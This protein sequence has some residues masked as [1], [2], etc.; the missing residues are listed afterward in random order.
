MKKTSLLITAVFAAAL[1]LPLAGC[2]NGA[3]EFKIDDYALPLDSPFLPAGTLSDKKAVTST[4]K[5]EGTPD[6]VLGN[7]NLLSLRFRNAEEQATRYKLFDTEA[8][9]FVTEE[10]FDHIKSAGAGFVNCAKLNANGS[11][12]AA[13]YS[14]AGERM[15]DAYAMNMYSFPSVTNE[16]AYVNGIASSVYVLR[17]FTAAGQTQKTEKYYLQNAVTGG[18]D[19]IDSDRVS[20]T[21]VEL[22]VG[23]PFNNYGSSSYLGCDKDGTGRTSSLDGWFAHTNGTITQTSWGGELFT[24][25]VAFRRENE[26]T[27]RNTAALKNAYVLG[28]FKGAFYYYEL[29]LAD[30]DAD[31]GYNVVF[32]SENGTASKYETSLIRRD[33]TTG[34]T[35]ALESDYFFTNAETVL[36]NYSARDFD[37]IYAEGYPYVNGV[38]VVS[39]DAAVSRLVADSEADVCLDLS[40]MPYAL[41]SAILR[42]KNNRYFTDGV[43]F[44]GDMNPVSVL[45]TAQIYRSLELI[46]ADRNNRVLAV[47][48]D[49]RIVLPPDYASLNFY[50][51]SAL[52]TVYEKNG[53]SHTQYVVNKNNPKGT[54]INEWISAPK[55]ALVEAR[56]GLITVTIETEDESLPLQTTFYNLDGVQIGGELR[57]GNAVTAAPLNDQYMINA[58]GIYFL[59]Y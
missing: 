51:G 26:F 8:K 59:I 1:A 19:P 20:A 35:T 10:E 4:M 32:V 56:G 28:F 50:G 31:E 30:P 3:N 22:Y 58:D 49:G 43:I 41:D 5:L 57:T 40:A 12:W 34:R 46:V 7:G 23:A 25:T 17:Y 14:P 54:V 33:L 36:Y 38:A 6:T 55:N 18:F 44:D 42:L 9:E 53:T 39:A 52:T 45:G 37:R 47:D 2:Q 27:A 13:V 29:T 21:P 11:L 15:L 16:T 24:G 48:F